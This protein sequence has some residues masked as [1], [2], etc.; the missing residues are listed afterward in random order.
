[1]ARVAN[2]GGAAGLAALFRDSGNSRTW[3]RMC[4]QGQLPGCE[5]SAFPLILQLAA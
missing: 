5:A 1:M 4:Q 3:L 2:D